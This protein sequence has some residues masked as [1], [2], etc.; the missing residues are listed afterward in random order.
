[1]LSINFIVLFTIKWYTQQRHPIQW[2]SSAYTYSPLSVLK[3][4]LAPVWV[5]AT[6]LKCSDSELSTADIA[7]TGLKFVASNVLQ[8]KKSYEIKNRIINNNN[9]NKTLW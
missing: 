5:T 7:I 2:G 1:M 8:K 3:Y 6:R 9:A 4:N